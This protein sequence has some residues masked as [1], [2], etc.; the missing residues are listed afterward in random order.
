MDHPECKQDVVAH[1]KKIDA[2]TKLASA[3]SAI[4]NSEVVK[5][6]PEGAADE[7]LGQ[8]A[9]VLEAV[10]SGDEVEKKE[11]EKKEG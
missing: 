7:L 2:K 6:A 1:L 5:S 11:V 9:F 10:S 4:E 3:K 8:L